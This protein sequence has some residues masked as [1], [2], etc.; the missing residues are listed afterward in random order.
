M[1][2]LSSVIHKKIDLRLNSIIL[3]IF[4]E[5]VVQRTR[6]YVFLIKRGSETWTRSTILQRNR[7][8]L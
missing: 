8:V 5:R 2:P 3:F 1:V 7:S 6:V 4:K